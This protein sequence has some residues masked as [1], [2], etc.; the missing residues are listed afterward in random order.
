L[1]GYLV[2]KRGICL[3]FQRVMPKNSRLSLPEND[4][5]ENVHIVHRSE[6]HI[7]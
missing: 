2:I 7:C 1:N 3:A 5:K 6:R 4:R